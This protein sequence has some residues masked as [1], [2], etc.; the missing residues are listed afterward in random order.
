MALRWSRLGGSRRW[1]VMGCGCGHGSVRYVVDRD[2]IIR[3]DN[4][5]TYNHIFH[6]SA[7]RSGFGSD[8]TS[9]EKVDD[10]FA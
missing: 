6:Y 10:R 1:S 8:Q 3:C 4:N 5:T 2:Y 7:R 9:D